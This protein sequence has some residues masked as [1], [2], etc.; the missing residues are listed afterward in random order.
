MWVQAQLMK[1]IRSEHFFSHLLY[2][3]SVEIG[4]LRIVF[5]QRRSLNAWFLLLVPITCAG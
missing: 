5:K 3:R 1:S 4:N 2:Y